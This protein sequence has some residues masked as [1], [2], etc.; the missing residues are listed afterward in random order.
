[1][2]S[3][4]NDARRVAVLVLPLVLFAA[5]CSS[6]A[7]L[8]FRCDS[9]INGGLLLTVDVVRATDEQARQI[10]STGEKWFYDPLR[11]T[12]RERITTVTF[13]TK[14]AG[15]DCVREVK[16]PMGSKDRY[17]VVV[18]DYRFQSPDASRHVVSL[19]R[20]KWKGD[21][22]RIAVKDR[23]LIVESR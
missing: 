18:A 13:P 3:G 10:Q 11:D 19:S 4:A 9:Q 22:I 8:R 21:T 15:G 23:E 1:M 12:M 17:V 6:S 7:N 2:R 5:A 14:D 20:E 16:V